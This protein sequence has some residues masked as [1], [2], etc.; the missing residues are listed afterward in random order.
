MRYIKTTI[1][2]LHILIFLFHIFNTCWRRWFFY[3]WIT[4]LKHKIEL[5]TCWPSILV[6]RCHRLL[7][8]GKTEFNLHSMIHTSRLGCMIEWRWKKYKMAISKN[9]YRVV[10]QRNKIVFLSKQIFSQI[11]CGNFNETWVACDETR[12]DLMEQNM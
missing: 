12:H 11:G 2:F 8:C 1:I 6:L 4:K 5:F 3:I 10:L 9:I 7:H